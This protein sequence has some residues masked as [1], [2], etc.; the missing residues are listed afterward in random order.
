GSSLTN[1]GVLLRQIFVDGAP[2]AVLD[3]ITVTVV[4]D[5]GETLTRTESGAALA[6]GSLIGVVYDTSPGIG[7]VHARPQV[8]LEGFGNRGVLI[9]TYG[10]HDAAGNPTG[11]H[12][13]HGNNQAGRWGPDFEFEDWTNQSR[14]LDAS[15]AIE[16]WIWPT[17]PSG[18]IWGYNTRVGGRA[19]SGDRVGIILYLDQ[20]TSDTAQLKFE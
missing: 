16:C 12:I 10:P 5:A 7:G 2:G 18:T 11:L 20:T 9:G 3:S 17:K 13:S 8:F 19:G 4:T 15:M 6:Q 1:K 14:L